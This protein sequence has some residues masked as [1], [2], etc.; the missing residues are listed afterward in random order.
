[1][2]LLATPPLQFRILELPGFKAANLV[3]ALALLAF[4]AGGSCL[5]KADAIHR[6]ALTA[7]GIYLALLTLSFFRSLPNVSR[8]HAIYPETYQA[9]AAEYWQSYYVVPV[10]FTFSFTYVLLRMRNRRGLKQTISAISLSVF[11]MSCSVIAV[12]MSHPAAILDMDPLRHATNALTERLLGMHY[13]AV[14]TL[15]MVTAP[16]L[17]YMALRRGSVWALNLAVAVVAV[18]LL[19]SRTGIFVFAGISVLTLLALGRAKALVALAPLVVG[20]A[21]AVLGKVLIGL[22]SMGFTKSGISTYALLSGNI[23]LCPS[24]GKGTG[25]LGSPHCRMV[26]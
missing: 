10:L 17:V 1:M 3:A 5:R 16:L 19:K 15:Y 26:Q 14:G 13:N 22:V 18:L 4:L 6:R 11:I 12:M 25:D 23:D 9:G 7:F 20:G 21:L 8:F 2:P 24:F